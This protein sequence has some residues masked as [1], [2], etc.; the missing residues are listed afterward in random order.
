CPMA[1]RKIMIPRQPVT[2]PRVPARKTPWERHASIIRDARQALARRYAQR[3]I[4]AC[5]AHGASRPGPP[6]GGPGDT[7]RS[8][9]KQGGSAR[10][11]RRRPAP[12]G[13]MPRPA[14]GT[15][16]RGP[17]GTTPRERHASIIR[18]ARQALARRYAQ[19]SRW[20]TSVYLWC[21][22]YPTA[23]GMGDPYRWW[24]N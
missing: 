10:P 13:G 22:L 24:S 2:P 19:R 8:S 23:A 17:A 12:R 18:D 15:P 20:S 21:A 9:A 4:E 11:R 7:A 5:G 3:S 16:P 14:L 1:T 6:V